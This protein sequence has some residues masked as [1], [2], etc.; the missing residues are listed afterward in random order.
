M[1]LLTR[2]PSTN[3]TTPEGEEDQQQ[4][5]GRYLNII[6]CAY[7]DG[8][9]TLWKQNK[10]TC[11]GD[12]D[13]CWEEEIIVGTTLGDDGETKQGP[14][15]T[16]TNTTSTTT[17]GDECFDSITDVDGVYK[18]KNDNRNGN[19][20]QAIIITSSSMGVKCYK[21]S[22]YHEN[23]TTGTSTSTECQKRQITYTKIA[24]Y[25]TASIKITAGGASTSTSCM[26]DQIILAVGTAM[27]RHNRIH[28][29][30]L[31]SVNMMGDN[32]GNGID[33]DNDNG[34]EEGASWKHQGS[35]LGHLGWVSCLDWLDVD[36]DA[37]SY[38]LLASGSHDA[39]IR[40]WKFHPLVGCD[41]N[42]FATTEE[43]QAIGVD[44]DREGAGGLEEGQGGDDESDEGDD[45]V[46]EG[47]ARMFIRYKKIDGT[48]VES[49]VTLEALLI[50]HEEN[51][52]AVSW[53]P[54]SPNPCLISSSMDRSILIW[55]EENDYTTSTAD[56]AT[57]TATI[58]E[59]VGNVWAPVTR[60]GTAGGILGGSVGSSLLGFVN[61]V[62]DGR[63][64]QII[65]HGY[66]GALYFWSRR[67][68]SEMERWRANPCIT[69][70]FRGC[71]D[72]SW[73]VSEG[74]YLL[75]AGLD[76]TCRLWTHLPLSSS[77]PTTESRIWREVGR[78]QVHGYDLNTVA[79]I[80]D[81]KN[82]M[83]HR[84]VSGADEKEARSFDAPIS[85]VKL[86]NFLHGHGS[87]IQDEEE[88]NR[89]ERAFIPSLGLSNRATADDAMEEDSY[90]NT[91][92]DHGI[93]NGSGDQ[94]AASLNSVKT[95]LEYLPHERDL[96]V[97]SL[98]PEI[99]KLYGHQTELVCLATN[100]GRSDSSKGG[101]GKGD[102]VFLASSCKARD[103]EN[104]SIRIWDVERN[105][106]VDI[107]KDGH[108]STVT[109]LS[110]SS[111]GRF[112]ASSGKDR[113]L[114]LWKRCDGASTATATGGEDNDGGT[115]FVLALLVE[116]AHK[117]IVWSLDFCPSDPTLLCTGSRDGYLKLWRVQDEDVGGDGSNGQLQLAIQELHRWQPQTSNQTSTSKSKRVE[118][119]TAVAFA[120][121]P[122]QSKSKSSS[123]LALGL[124][125]GLV[126]IWAVPLLG[127]A[128]DDETTTTG[129]SC[130][131]IHLVP[132][133]DC[134]IGPVKKLAW[135]PVKKSIS[136]ASTATTTKW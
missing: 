59:G 113:R 108:K 85:T 89:I 50:G 8:T 106:C 33:G 47:E 120:P 88:K 34:D 40:L 136:N 66:G 49:A 31:S 28:L 94:S 71:S 69:G 91:V 56:T 100:A 82:E 95:M 39:R 125:S 9:L 115:K 35:L 15:V 61:V 112:L 135:K 78:P 129:I 119:I 114:C 60:V 128:K 58:I 41:E 24:N 65:G 57:G 110:F 83:K 46:E 27:P 124:E 90:G 102:K 104:A 25:P 122:L 70:H 67:G 134:H 99:R 130:R 11:G 87:I 14:R 118:P 98:W 111:D 6:A 116:S 53:R 22:S 132:T 131:L 17:N 64:R 20:I 96:G 54:M 26:K 37:G 5:V 75:S 107:L 52:T 10:N 7:S 38:M 23:K 97:T 44:G 19:Q 126:E 45:L 3:T 16:T 30:S 127:T 73:E 117:R 36:A 48:M 63:G 79:C 123:I 29:Y 55:M 103:A 109:A 76:Q 18:Y 86:L 12:S 2:I 101:S 105:M 62:W 68:N 77:L 84:F 43:Q 121:L 1:K 13:D 4:G 21:C 72:I 42:A 74:L 133:T 93:T 51:V 81:G 92:Q 80:G 32:N